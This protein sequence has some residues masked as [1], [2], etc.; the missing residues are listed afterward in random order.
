MAKLVAN[1][2][3]LTEQTKGFA[4]LL[5][6]DALA[7]LTI[8][9][10]KFKTIGAE[11]VRRVVPNLQIMVEDFERFL[12]S[13]GWD[14]IKNSLLSIASVLKFMVEHPAAIGAL[15][16]FSAGSTFGIKGAGIGA[17]LGAVGFGVMGLAKGGSF[18]TSGPTPIMV[19][20]NPGGK[21][22]VTAMPLSGGGGGV[23]MDTT[24]I[25]RE[26]ST[27]KNEMTALRSDM[28]SYF[29]FGGSAPK[30]FGR[31]TVRGLETANNG[32]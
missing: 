17:L 26:V 16:G 11:I 9:I 20:D 22:L 14:R 3:K 28:K 24:P 31:E 10:N 32:V 2:G 19:G 1:Q 25:A 23:Q 21:E 13:G 15:L 29:G 8:I 4:Q 12:A 18:V 27:L 7:S 30:Q 5:G 6:K